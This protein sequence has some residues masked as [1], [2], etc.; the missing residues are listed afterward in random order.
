MVCR[1]INKF[2]HEG[3][4]LGLDNGY[5]N[6]KLLINIIQETCVEI[7]IPDKNNASKNKEKII[8]DNKSNKKIR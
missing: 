3:F 6:L 8:K 4:D 7:V 5:W 2:K 1:L